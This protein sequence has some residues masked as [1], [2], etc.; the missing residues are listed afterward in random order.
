MADILIFFCLH[1]NWPVTNLVLEFK[2]QK[3]Y[4]NN[5]NE[6]GRSNFKADKRISKCQSFLHRVYSQKN[7]WF[8]VVII[9]RAKRINATRVCPLSYDL[10]NK[11]YYPYPDNLSIQTNIFIS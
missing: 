2:S 10:G 5:L 11:G 9:I 1:S 3:E 6:A 8:L 4:F 7:E